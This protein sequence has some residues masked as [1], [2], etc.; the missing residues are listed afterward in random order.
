MS[1]HL[2]TA[3]EE[4][5]AYNEQVVSRSEHKKDEEEKEESLQNMMNGKDRLNKMHNYLISKQSIK[6]VAA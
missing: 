6:T 2:Q 1:S 4:A 5:V 3:S